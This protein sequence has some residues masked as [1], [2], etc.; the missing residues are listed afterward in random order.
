MAKDVL[1][2]LPVYWIDHSLKILELIQET[3]GYIPNFDN[4]TDLFALMGNEHLDHSSSE[5]VTDYFD[6][7][8]NLSDEDNDDFHYI[9]D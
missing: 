5:Q 9:E 2:C 3:L 1:E 6:D 7:Y 8:F 4:F